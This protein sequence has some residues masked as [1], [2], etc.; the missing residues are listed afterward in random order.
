[1]QNVDFAL[2]RG[3]VIAGR[4]TDADGRPIVEERLTLVLADQNRQNQ[5]MFG[6]IPA[7]GAQ[8]DDRGVYRIYG[9]VPGRYKISVGRDDD[10][11][12]WP[13]AFGR[14]GYERT[15]FPDTVDQASAKVIEVTEGSEIPNVDITIGRP[16]PAFVASGKVV[17]AET[18]QP[19]SGLRIG[20]RRMMKNDYAGVN[21]AAV[22]NRLGDFR[23]ENLTPGKYA[24]MLLP[25]QG[26]ETRA[27]AVPFE[28]VD[29]DVTGLLVK[30]FKGLTVS[31][32]V[33]IEGK[34]EN[35]ILAKLAELRIRAYVRSDGPM[36]SFGNI[37]IINADGSFSIGGLT[38]GIA[39]FSLASPAGRPPVNFNIV[40]VERD[41]VV[42]PRGVELTAGESQVAGVKIVLR[43]GTGSVKGEVRSENGPLPGEAHVM[44]WIKKVGENSP[45]FRTYFTDL[46]GH[47]L[48]EG[49]SAGDYELQVQA[50]VPGRQAP[51]VTES[52]TVA[53]G[54][55][56]DV[57]V[58]VD[59]KPNPTP[60]DQ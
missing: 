25:V 40:R 51:P 11:Y 30:T 5:Q 46:R 48:I 1:V 2:E 57:V 4:V 23:L 9:L 32:F 31:G 19:V 15:Y 54:T 52:V 16:L 42:Q 37:S 39:N 59:L 29:Q 6:P 7:A 50:T 8:T 10:S 14:P 34:N 18:G 45:N 49:L 12:Y 13:G 22:A 60:R 20:L 21:A 53:D 27:D 41:G 56:S 58:T 24:L 43:Y 47:F 33:V 26:L 35:T 36:Q 28:V 3:G 44:V 17:D 55:V 38:A